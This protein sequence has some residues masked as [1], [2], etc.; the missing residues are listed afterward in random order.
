MD[1]SRPV[2]SS[3]LQTVCPYCGHAD[4]DLFE[5]IDDN[6]LQPLHCAECGQTSCFVVMEC[7]ACEAEHLFSWRSRPSAE[8]LQTLRCG[9]CERRYEDHETASA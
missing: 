6:S 5:A 3:T 2:M 1:I 7:Q 8:R 4:D 9:H